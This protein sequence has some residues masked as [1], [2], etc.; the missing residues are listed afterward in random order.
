MDSKFSRLFPEFLRDHDEYKVLIELAG[1]SLNEKEEEIESFTELVDVD[2]CPDKFLPCLAN[3]VGYDYRY[4]ISDDHNREIIKNIFKIYSMR[5]T[6][7]SIIMAATHGNNKGYIGGEIFV[8]GT[9]TDEIRAEVHYPRTELFHHSRSKYSGRHHRV[10]DKV[11]RE[12]VIEVVVTMFNDTIREAV[13][14]VKPA[15]LRLRFKLSVYP[16]DG[17][18]TI[19]TEYPFIDQEIFLSIEREVKVSYADSLMGH[20]SRSIRSGSTT[21]SG[22]QVIYGR[23]DLMIT[24]YVDARR[25]ILVSSP[26]YTFYNL[27]GVPNFELL[28]L[29]LPTYI[30]RYFR[31]IP[32]YSDR[33]KWS[34]GRGRSGLNGVDFNFVD[35]HREPLTSSPLYTMEEIKH[36]R[37]DERQMIYQDPV[38]FRSVGH[39]DLRDPLEIEY[40]SICNPMTVQDTEYA[41][42]ERTKHRHVDTNIKYMDP[43]VGLPSQVFINYGSTR[44]NTLNQFK[45]KVISDI[46]RKLHI[47]ELE[48]TSSTEDTVQLGTDIVIYR[49]NKE[50]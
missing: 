3:L 9:F 26:I 25:R 35:Y 29:Q 5:G 17:N 49:D 45:S 1:M 36:L 30:I 20:S 14:R 8:P 46:G 4:D 2:S 32:T 13:S 42:E 39:D 24:S 48:V 37:L 16:I 44:P 7:E 40:L 33:F 43:D 28:D 21:Y 6:D 23:Y 12:G 19:A 27:S 15:G 10:D 31:G 18:P 38:K 11:Y 50:E 47:A 41:F 34:N 22:R